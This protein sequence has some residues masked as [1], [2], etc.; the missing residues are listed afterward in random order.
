MQCSFGVDSHWALN[1]DDLL[2]YKGTSTF[3]ACN[4]IQNPNLPLTDAATWRLFITKP[5]NGYCVGINVKATKAGGTLTKQDQA[6]Y[7]Y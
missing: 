4:G 5:A 1:A 6:P 7:G 2:L 3:Y